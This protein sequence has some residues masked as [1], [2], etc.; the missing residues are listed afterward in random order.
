MFLQKSWSKEVQS[1]VVTDFAVF[2]MISRVNMVI[3]GVHAVMVN[4]GVIAP[5]GMRMVALAARNYAVPLVMVAGTHKLCPLY[6]PNPEASAI[7]DSRES[8]RERQLIKGSS[9]PHVSRV[10]PSKREEGFQPKERLDGGQ[11]QIR[12][13]LID[14][15]L[16]GSKRGTGRRWL[17]F[18]ACCSS[19]C[20]YQWI[21]EPSMKIDG[22]TGKL[23]PHRYRLSD[24]T[25]AVPI[26]VNIKYI[27]G[28]HGQKTPPVAKNNV[29]IGRMPIMLRS[30]C[31]VLHGKD[32][33][34]K[35][36]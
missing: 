23:S 18:S 15:K 12:V 29:I 6:P 32:G 31:C 33:T 25:Y 35:T 4:G 5:V 16:N 24:I 14:K 30:C 34:C 20:S 26:Y 28:S 13:G 7:E 9:E 1:T 8:P 3:V 22:V 21:D 17:A 36:W 2:S 10:N 19:W 27:T 11:N